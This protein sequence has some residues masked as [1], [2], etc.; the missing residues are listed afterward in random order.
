[1]LG[2]PGRNLITPKIVFSADSRAHSLKTSLV[3]PLHRIATVWTSGFTPADHER[4]QV[5]GDVVGIECR[6]GERAYGIGSVVAG[7]C[8]AT[9]SCVVEVGSEHRLG[10]GECIRTDRR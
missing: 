4:R 7:V 6:T 10:D 9:Q 5:A 2:V 8:R 3:T 1:M